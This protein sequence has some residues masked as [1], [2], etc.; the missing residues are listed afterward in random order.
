[1]GVP[2]SAAAES[3]MKPVPGDWA[4]RQPVRVFRPEIAA[5]IGLAPA[6]VLDQLRYWLERATKEHDGHHWVYKT[7]EELGR[8][9]GIAKH[10][11]R[12]ALEVL[13]EQRIVI[14]IR[15]PHY[16]RDSTLW[17]RIDSMGIADLESRIQRRMRL[18]A[19][20]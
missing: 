9:L 13:R 12:Y 5:E 10:Q 15:N 3:G 16:R 6:I 4:W 8:D 19:S 20:P 18:V 2:K 1:M 7:Y 17:W 11:V 14:S